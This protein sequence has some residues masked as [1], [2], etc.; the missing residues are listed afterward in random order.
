MTSNTKQ[1]PRC[2]KTFECNSNDITN[3]ACSTIHIP[4]E[5]RKKIALQYNDCLCIQCIKE[6]KRIFIEK[7]KK[8][9]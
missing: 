9:L 8:Y 3:C 7:N 2:N 4:D 6:L 1:C 5:M